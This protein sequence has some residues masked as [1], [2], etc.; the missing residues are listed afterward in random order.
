MTTGWRLRM[1][2]RI[3]RH[4]DAKRHGVKALYVFGIGSTGRRERQRHRPAPARRR[5][6]RNSAELETWLR[7]W[8]SAS[9]R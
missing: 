4:L 1:A 5:E 7:G 9:R 6:R 3:A 8:A 2:E